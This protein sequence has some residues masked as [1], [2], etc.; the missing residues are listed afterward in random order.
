MRIIH[1]I[2]QLVDVLARQQPLQVLGGVAAQ[3]NRAAFDDGYEIV[4]VFLGDEVL[5]V[6]DD[7]G[8]FGEEAAGWLGGGCWGGCWGGQNE[9]EGEEGSKFEE[10]HFYCILWCR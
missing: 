10:M 5:D 9:G 1:D 2:L 4:D 3:E 7:V 8:E 6:V